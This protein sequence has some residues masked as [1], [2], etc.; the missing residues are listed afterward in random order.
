MSL[1]CPLC[2]KEYATVCSRD[3]LH[4][5]V[6]TGHFAPTTI[7]THDGLHP[8]QFAPCPGKNLHYKGSTFHRIVKN[9]MIQVRGGEWSL[10]DMYQLSFAVITTDKESIDPNLSEASSCAFSE[11][12]LNLATRSPQV[13][14]WHLLSSSEASQVNHERRTSAPFQGGDFESGNGT[15][16]ESIYG[17]TFADECFARNHDEPFLL[18]MA[19]RGKDTNGSQF[20]ILTHKVG[21]LKM[22]ATQRCRLRQGTGWFR[23][24]RCL[25]AS[26]SFLG[27]SF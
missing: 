15:G 13:R 8:S 1:S 16:G 25:R 9:F 17:G 7:C 24:L 26:E 27:M 23:C 5:T 12:F 11:A 18:S 2:T 6:C 4:P 14:A 19:N 21:G 20:F 10:V 3:S 22:L